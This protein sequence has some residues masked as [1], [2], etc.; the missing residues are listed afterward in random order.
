[1]LRSSAANLVRAV[2][3]TPPPEVLKGASEANR[4]ASTTVNVWPVALRHAG[5]PL[6]PIALVEG[7]FLAVAVLAL[8]RL[9]KP[10]PIP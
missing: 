5:V 4:H 8:R 1:M 9:G 10:G 7:G 3:G 6:L 2:L